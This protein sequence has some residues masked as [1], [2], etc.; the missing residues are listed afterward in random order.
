MGTDELADNQRWP[1]STRRLIGARAARSLGQGA[2]MVSFALYLHALGWSPTS[3][4]AVFTAGLFLDASLVLLVGP[5]SD[6][7]GHRRFLLFFDAL[8]G[9]SALVALLTAQPFYLATAAILGGLGRGMNGGSGPFVPVELAWLAQPLPSERRGPVYSMNSGVGFF[10]MGVGA[11]LGAFPAFFTI[12]LPGALAYRPLFALSILSS[13]AC[14]IIL[15][16]ADDSPSKRP[17]STQTLSQNKTHTQSR[18]AFENTLLI[19][20]VGVNALNGIGNG[21]VGPLLAYWFLLKFGRGPGDIGPIMGISF[22]VAGATSL[23][24]VKLVSRHGVVRLVTWMRGVGVALLLILPFIPNFWWASSLLIIRSALNRGTAGARQALSVSLVRSKRRGVAASL[25][26]A[27]LQ[28]PRAI[29]PLFAGLLFGGGF[30][31]APF[32]LAAG[33]QA[34][35]LIL[36]Q[37]I[38]RHHEPGKRPQ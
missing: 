7:L 24:V 27:S 29:G 20:L 12:W 9:F 19:K 32:I 3:I 38:F 25:D 5:L 23:W 31:G 18:S 15:W 14:F 6:R 28:M 4:G 2:L 33:F 21:L 17:Q 30:L 34:S 36:Y 22:L 13:A 16:G 26:R 8:Q 10:G 37:L 11:F 35:F 1:A